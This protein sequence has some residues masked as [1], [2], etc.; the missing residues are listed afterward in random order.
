LQYLLRWKGYFATHDSW[1][2]TA[3]A[4]CLDLIQE[5]YMANP[6]AV[7]TVGTK[8]YINPLDF[9]QET[10][11]ISSLSSMDLSFINDICLEDLKLDQETQAALTLV[12]LSDYHPTLDATT[13][14][15][16]SPAPNHVTIS[17]AS[18][19][20]STTDSDSPILRA[21]QPARFICHRTW[22][23][24]DVT[25]QSPSTEQLL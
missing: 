21:P 19:E 22:N 2:A 1:E 11:S 16:P 8:G 4:N 15:H 10:I 13:A 14:F 6:T 25:P 20:S 5:F 12:N 18:T 24:P 3:D 7:R 9:P 17:L 23:I